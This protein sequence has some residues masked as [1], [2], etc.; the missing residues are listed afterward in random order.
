MDK[1]DVIDLIKKFENTWQDTI[2]AFCEEFSLNKKQFKKWLK[3]KGSYTAGELA[4]RK[5][6]EQDLHV[7]RKSAC[8]NVLRIS[9][10]REFIVNLAKSEHL[11]TLILVDGDACCGEVRKFAWIKPESKI[12]FYFIAIGGAKTVIPPWWNGVNSTWIQLDEN[13]PNEADYA[14]SIAASIW[15]NQNKTE[16]YVLAR[17]KFAE[18]L[19]VVLNKTYGVNCYG[20][21]PTT[22]NVSL[23]YLL[24]SGPQ[25]LSDKAIEIQQILNSWKVEDLQQ[26]IPNLSNQTI[27]ILNEIV[28][29]RR[30]SK[31]KHVEN[32]V[33]KSSSEAFPV[34]IPKT[35]MLKP[36]YYAGKASQTEIYAHPYL[37]AIRDILQKRKVISLAEIGQLYPSSGLEVLGYNKWAYLLELPEVQNMLNADY[38]PAGT[39][40]P[41]AMLKVRQ[42]VAVKN[43]V[44]NMSDDELRYEW[45]LLWK[46]DLNSFCD[47]YQCNRGHF[48]SWL[49][50][51]RLN[52]PGSSAAVRQWIKDT[53]K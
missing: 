2:G 36:T 33:T 29:R 48:S 19:S 41:A 24:Q 26:K 13:L 7:K 9:E 10:M 51:R 23:V 53:G 15:I 44:D 3:Q 39:G 30:I 28:L 12:A 4:V 21:D 37:M 38:I 52:S 14:I 45:K 27:S 17:D 50:K 32:I 25:E 31:D 8:C 18:P 20:I 5:F 16:L 49:H 35:I 42:T 40:T 34:F 1:P 43:G 46:Q 22:V 6:F 11:K 47:K